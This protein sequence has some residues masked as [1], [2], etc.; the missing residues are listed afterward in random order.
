MNMRR[1]SYGLLLTFAG[2]IFVAGCGDDPPPATPP[3]P[4]EAPAAEATPP[5]PPKEEPPPPPPAK[6]AKERFQGKFVQAFDGQ[7]KDNAEAA[8]VNAAGKNKDGGPKDQ[9]KYDASLDKTKTATA[10]NTLQNTGDMFEWDLKGKPVHK[11]HYEVANGTDTALSIKLGKDD[12]SKKDMKA[13]AVDITFSD[14]NTFSM[15]DPFAPGGKGKTLVF[16]RQ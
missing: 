11:V 7:V 8:A 10:D 1:F 13:Q 12:Q 15:K 9:K 6:P 5:P 16:K 4:A 3:Q 14:E 2:A